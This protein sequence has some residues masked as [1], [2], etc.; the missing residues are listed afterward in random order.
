MNERLTASG[1]LQFID[2][3]R[4]GEYESG[5]A[6]QTVNLTLSGLENSIGKLD[7]SRPTYV[8]CQGGYRSSAATSILEKK[9]FGEIYNISGGTG[10]WIKA[11]LKVD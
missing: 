3:R 6:A 8:I 11:G 7:A 2:V 1:D 10:A 5:H 4:N 9:G